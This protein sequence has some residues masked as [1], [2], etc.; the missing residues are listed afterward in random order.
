MIGGLH[1]ALERRVQLRRLRSDRSGAVAVE[2][3]C[4]A[5][6]LFFLILGGVESGRLL[7]TQSALEMSVAQAARCYAWQVS[8]CTTATA[9]QSFATTVAPQLGFPTTAF[10]A[11]SATCGAQVSASYQYSF[12]ASGLFPLTPTLTASACFPT[13]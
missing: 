8:G 2:F 5:P 13:A 10:T 3:A 1:R 9:T 12:I 11:K 4:I 7:W 6:A